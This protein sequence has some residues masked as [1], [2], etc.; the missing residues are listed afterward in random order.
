MSR[1]KAT[2]MKCPKCGHKFGLSAKHVEREPQANR[3]VIGLIVVTLF[4]LMVLAFA[5]AGGVL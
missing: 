5:A 1:R 2:V 4:G 3:F